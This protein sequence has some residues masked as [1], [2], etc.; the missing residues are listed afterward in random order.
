[1]K[2]FATLG[3]AEEVLIL[4]IRPQETAECPDTLYLIDNEDP[5]A[6]N[7]NSLNTNPGNDLQMVDLGNQN[8]IYQ[9]S[10]NYALNAWNCNP[11]E[12]LTT[13]LFDVQQ[14]KVVKVFP[15]PFKEQL[16]F[17]VIEKGTSANLHIQLYDNLGRL[18][19][20]ESLG[21]NRLKIKVK[22]ETALY[23]YQIIDLD[24]NVMN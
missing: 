2:P 3:S 4:T 13:S 16:I 11:N 1:M 14:K 9:Y 5:F 22:P 6:I 17:E 7:P 24:Q 12:N 20:K 10:E 18:L 23:F 15:N 21:N 8:A 19:H